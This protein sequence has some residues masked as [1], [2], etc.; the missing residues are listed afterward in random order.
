MFAIEGFHP[1]N[2]AGET[3]TQYKDL[4]SALPLVTF[5][6]SLF[7]SSF[8]TSKFMLNGPIRFISNNSAVNGM[9]S[10]SFLCVFILNTMFGFRV[11]CIENAFFTSY[12]L[13]IPKEKWDPTNPALVDTIEITP[14]INPEYRLLI[15]LAPCVI[16]FLINAF[17]LYQTT[18]GMWKYFLQYPQFLISP[19]FTPF[20]F[21][22]YVSSNQKRKCQ[23]KIWKRGT[24]F[25]AIYIGCIPQM[26]LLIT[27]YYK[28]LHNWKNEVM[29]SNST[30]K[31]TNDALFKSEYGNRIFAT[32]TSILF[33]AL[34]IIFFQCDS[35]FRERRVH[36]KC[37]SILC[38]PCPNSCINYKD[39]SLNPSEQNSTS[40][41]P[42]GDENLEAAEDE[43]NEP[44]TIAS[45][46]HTEVY[47]YTKKRN[48]FYLFGQT[49]EQNDNDISLVC[50]IFHSC[51]LIYSQ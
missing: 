32:S 10:V 9:L 28:G 13:P 26:V 51:L 37:L 7:A 41:N 47:L 40:C 6:I 5:V 24:I 31:E 48:M 14:V 3:I 4:N 46:L 50:V 39:P 20:L 23:L 18:K 11:I 1:K 33:L 29:L 35:L 8:G 38:C 43:K 25:N 36:C 42:D 2:I 34:I 49:F 45:Q 12:R 17:K 30:D 27:D 21:E 22:G 15:Y 44:K 16:P 19:C